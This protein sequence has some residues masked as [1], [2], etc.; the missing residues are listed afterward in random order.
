LREYLFSKID[1]AV[2]TSA[3]LA[4]SGGFDYIR[5]RLGVQGARELVVPSHF[6]Y[7]RQA[8]LYLPP[9][10]PDPRTPQFAARAAARVRELLEITQGRAFCLFTSYAQMREIYERLLG[11]IGYPMLLQGT[12]PRSAL[13][14]EF[15]LTPNA[16][17]FATA[18]FWQGVDVQGEQ[19]SAVIIDR[20]PF[21]VPNDPVVA[22]RV[23]AIDAAGGNAFYE[24]QVPAAVITLKQ[25][26]G[27]LIRSLND[28]GL[29]ALLDNRLLKKSYGKVF[30]E[31]LPPY[32]RAS[33]LET[34]REFF[35][36]Q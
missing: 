35:H 10:L 2:L 17:L 14:E 13:L 25:G 34:V 4:V 5:G 23:R 29:L 30:L 7:A 28:R 36:R 32:S 6:D 27:R 15:R 26:F 8:L 11:E 12:A 24:Y 18:S 1:C 20:L 3:T 19:L 21:A 16:V 9:D 31:S 22:A 33:E